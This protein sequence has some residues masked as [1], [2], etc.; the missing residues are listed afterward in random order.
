MMKKLTKKIK[1]T[2]SLI[3]L[4]TIQAHPGIFNWI[5][6]HKNHSY[7]YKSLHSIMVLPRKKNLLLNRLEIKSY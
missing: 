7:L 4:Y 6:K 5:N 2:L 1:K 3:N